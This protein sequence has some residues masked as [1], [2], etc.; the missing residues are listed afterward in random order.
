M[1]QKLTLIIAVLMSVAFGDEVVIAKSMFLPTSDKDRVILNVKG[2][3]KREMGKEL[4]AGCIKYYKKKKIRVGDSTEYYILYTSDNTWI[5]NCDFART[6][7]N[8]PNVYELE[9]TWIDDWSMQI[10]TATQDKQTKKLNVEL[11]YSRK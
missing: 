2:S 10:W 7:P 1:M 4:A 6:N 8:N 9:I 5:A 11:E 3:N